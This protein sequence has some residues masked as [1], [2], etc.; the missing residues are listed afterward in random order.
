MKHT[1]EEVIDILTKVKNGAKWEW[2]HRDG[3]GFPITDSVREL[4]STFLDCEVRIKQEPKTGPLG[5]ED[6]VGQMWWVRSSPE[7]SYPAL[8]CGIYSE[9]IAIQGARVAFQVMFQHK[10]GRT[11]DG[12]N[13]EP[14]HKTIES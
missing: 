13:W 9:G 7:D 3:W 12:K 4:L 6:F 14:C 5:P 2:K 1:P 8:V 11:K 10:W